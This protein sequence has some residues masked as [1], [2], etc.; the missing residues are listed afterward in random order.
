[1][2]GVASPVGLRLTTA[3]VQTLSMCGFPLLLFCCCL[4]CL[5]VSTWWSSPSLL[6]RE[7]EREGEREREREGERESRIQIGQKVREEKE[8]EG[9]TQR[10]RERE[11]KDER[12]VL[13]AVV[14]AA[15]GGA[16]LK[17]SLSWLLQW[18]CLY[19]LYLLLRLLL[20]LLLVPVLLTSFWGQQRIEKERKTIWKRG[21]AE[22]RGCSFLVQSREELCAGG[23]LGLLWRQSGEAPRNDVLSL[24]GWA[25]P[26]SCYLTTGS[27]SIYIKRPPHMLK[28]HEDTFLSIHPLI[29]E[30]HSAYK[31]D[32]CGVKMVKCNLLI[33]GDSQFILS[34]AQRKT[35]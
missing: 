21:R 16:Q 33:Y 17:N 7:K 5:S 23:W 15:V 24:G 30:L 6:Q 20:L 11:H 1:M 31:G 9:E 29:L 34:M 3:A 32:L 27:L 10:E 2:M 14:N 28:V 19:C 13:R 25:E 12:C 18:L 8:E 22:R 4:R 35:Q 26:W